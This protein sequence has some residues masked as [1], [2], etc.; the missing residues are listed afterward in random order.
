MKFNQIHTAHFPNFLNTL[1]LLA[2]FTLLTNTLEINAQNREDVVYLKNG[3]I[4]RGIIVPDSS[5]LQK[6]RILNNSG[7]LWVF[8]QS[9]VDSIR[10]EKPYIG[11][12][13]HFTQPGLEF[14]IS[15]EFLV[16]SGV[17][18]IGNSVIPGLNLQLSYRYNDHLAMGSE[19]GLEFYN[20][21]EI[22]LSIAFRYRIGNTV[23]SPLLFI[24]TGYTIPAED[25]E[26]D[27]EYRYISKGGWHYSIGT[28]F[29]K[30]LSNETS[31]IF[32]LAYHYQEF[33]YHLV[34]L[35]PWSMERNR[36]EAYSRL[37]LSLG[38][39]FK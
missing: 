3:S 22:P 16:R 28:G 14:G 36:T 24:R 26:S 1:L 11:K 9:E 33:N 35:Q 15:G 34:P 19:L 39:I 31:F 7:D 12:L 29:E 4:L 25:R 10:K 38:Y 23:S 6:V 37:R 13:Q 5:S 17:N 32:T 27:W 2:I 30:I 18:A 8:N 20:W 21:M